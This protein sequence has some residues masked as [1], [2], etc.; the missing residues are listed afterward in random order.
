MAETEH[1]ENASEEAVQ[2]PQHDRAAITAKA[3]ALYRGLSLAPMVRASTTPL[4]ALALNYGADFVYTEELVDRAIIETIRVENKEM[5][6]IDYI[7]DPAKLSKKAKKKLEAQNN[8]PCLIMRI[9][10][11]LEANKLVCQ[12]GTGEPELALK[13]AKHVCRDVS[14]IDVNMG[15]PKK[16]SVSGGMGSALLSDPERAAKIIATLKK[17]IMLPI[18]C[19]I[20]LLKDVEET[21]AFIEKMLEAGVDA[22]AIHARRVGH[23]ATRKAD[24]QTLQE[25][26]AVVQPKYPNFPFLING[27]FYDRQERNEIM[28]NTNAQGIL[29]ARPALYN[30]ST[31]LPISQLVDKT[32]LVQEYLRLVIRYD[33]HYKNTKYVLCEMMSNRRTPIER[34]P[35]MPIQFPGGQTIGNTCDCHDL[36]SLCRLWNVNY[37]DTLKSVRDTTASSLSG[38]TTSMPAGEHKYEDSYFL[39]SSADRVMVEL[40]DVD[41]STAE[42]CQCRLIC[43]DEPN[44]KRAK[45]EN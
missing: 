36:E 17:E 28:K 2:T 10:P 1:V 37:S 35:T 23:D 7:K 32:Q 14:A 30:M 45:V 8:R 5:R 33:M 39:N 25:V 22:L 4:R 34:V 21:V 15:C 24:W 27:D 16:F 20:R 29:L 31:F 13:A 43:T 18:S 12:L 38:G 44:P 6:T 42:T 41:E 40:K 9:D 11:T 26:M 19:K 3:R